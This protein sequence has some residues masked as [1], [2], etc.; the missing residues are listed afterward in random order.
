[1]SKIQNKPVCREAYVEK[2]RGAMHHRAQWLYLLLDEAKKRGADWEEIARAATSRCGCFQGAGLYE[3]WT[4]HTSLKSFA[5]VF[6]DEDFKKYFDME[7][8]ESTE[9]SLQIKFHHCP[10]VAGW[11][12]IGCSDEEIS[13][14]CDIAM[15]GD[16]N[17]ANSCHLDFTLNS[18]Y[19]RS[20]QN[21]WKFWLMSPILNG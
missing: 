15:D 3:D 19:T 18:V 10:L 8:V 11:Q 1:M 17:I 12:A 6:A 4:D 13:K 5:E 2:V 20:G 14:L 7:I 21:C 9:S 16:R